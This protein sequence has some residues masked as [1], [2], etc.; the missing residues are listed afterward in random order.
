MKIL[1]VASADSPLLSERVVMSLES[2]HEIVWYSESKI[3]PVANCKTVHYVGLPAL[4]VINKILGSFVFFWVYFREKPDVLHVHWAW[5]LPLLFHISCP[6]IVSVMG[7]DVNLPCGS[8]VRKFIAKT[9]LKRAT[10]ITSKSKSM[11][12]A[13]NTLGDNQEKIIRINWGLGTE[14][15]KSDIPLVDLKNKYK[16]G[17]TNIIFFSPRALQP[18]YRV[19]DVVRAFVKLCQERDD[20]LLLVACMNPNEKIVTEIETL[21]LEAQL[22]H[23]VI[24]CGAL[25]KSAMQQHY[26]LS[27]AV[28]SYARSD[29]LPQSLYESMASGSFPIFTALPCYSEILN[30]GKNALLCDTKN[31][32]IIYN[33]MKAYLERHSLPENQKII[34]ENRDYVLRNASRKNQQEILNQLYT[35]ALRCHFSG[36]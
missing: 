6:K 8:K 36:G 7:T 20:I 29:G 32:Q 9:A 25:D 11:D 14:W 5:F 12:D 31:P 34:E 13:I 1:V 4:G 19:A 28:V 33:K 24:L 18:L 17:D 21:V 15:F 3:E 26:Q 30:D 27:H 35:D 16:T 22:Q 23:R 2:G 10:F